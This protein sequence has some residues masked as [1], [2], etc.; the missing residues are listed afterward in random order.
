MAFQVSLD[1]ALCTDIR[2]WV[3]YQ[4][5]IILIQKSI[6]KELLAFSSRVALL[7]GPGQVELS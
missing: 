1:R 3:I 6:L 2:V 4:T 5:N 7:C